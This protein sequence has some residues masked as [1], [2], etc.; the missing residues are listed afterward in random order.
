MHENGLESVLCGYLEGAVSRLSLAFAVLCVLFLSAPF[1]HAT[2]TVVSKTLTMVPSTT[3]YPTAGGAPAITLNY[4]TQYNGIV[5]NSTGPACTSDPVITITPNTT[6]AGGTF[7]PATCN[8]TFNIPNPSSG[9]NRSG[10]CS[11][12][13][14][15]PAAPAGNY[16]V[17]AAAQPVPNSTSLVITSA[18]STPVTLFRVPTVTIANTTNGAEAGPVN[19]RLTVTQ[20]N[21]LP[22]DT[23]ISLGYGGTAANGTDYTGP[24][25]VTILAGST[26][27]IVTL[28]TVDDALVE[29]SET[30]IV[31]LTGIT[32]GSAT[33]G[34]TTSATN[35][36][37]DND[38]ANVTIANTTDGAEPATA[39]TLT[40]TQSA[41]AATNT[42][43]NLTYGGTATNVTDYT[44]PATVTISAGSTTATVTLPVVD[45]STLEGTETVIVTLGS[46]ASGLATLGTPRVATNTIADN[47]TAS[48]AINSVS[49]AESGGSATFTATLTGVTQTAFTV[50]YATSDGT[51]LAGL[52]YTTRTGTLSF[53]ANTASPQ[54]RTFTVPVTNDVIVEATETATVTLSGL[55]NTFGGALTIT[56]PT[57]TL[58]I[59]DNDTAAVTIANTTN[60][61]EAGLV[62]G[63]MT[64]SQSRQSSTPTTVSYTVSGT[65]T[66][67][68]DYTPLSGSVVIPA[69]ALTASITIPILQDSLV[70]GAEA[71][72]VSL[73]AATSNVAITASGSATNTIADDDS[74]AVT[75][76]NTTDGNEA[77]LVAGVMTLSLSNPSATPTTVSY[78]VG[79]LASAATDYSAL[80]GSVVILA[81]ALTA[82][83]T[84]P[85]LQD[86]LVEGSETVIVNLSAATSNV[87][88]TASG[89]ATNTIADDDTSA[90][91]IANTTDGNEAGLVAGVMT[92]SL[93]NQSATPTTVSYSVSGSATSGTDYTVLSG[94]VIIPA[95]ALTATIT[96]PVLQD[97]LVEGSETVI[98]ALTA[99][100]SNVAITASG[101]ATNTLADDDASA[102]TIANTTDG[103]EAGLVAGITTV[104]LSNPSATPTTVSYI[105]S[106]SATSGTDYTALSGTVIVP[107]NTL[108]ATI[109]IPVLQDSIVEGPETVIV[110]LTAATSNVAITASGSA[111]NTLADDDASAATIANT[112]DG[113]EAGLVAGIMTVSLSN[114]SATPT[115]VS[116]SVNG[117]ATSGTD[118]TALSGSVIIPA[119][120]LT[121]TITI[122]V[123]QDSLVEGSETVIIALTS[124][125]SNVAITA[126]GSATNTMADD[127]ASAVTIANT[128]DGN[129]AGLVAGV[130]TVSLSNPSA[131][132]TTVSY[133]VSGSATSGTDYTALSGFVIVP[134][135]TLTATITI[136]VLQDS[137][138]EGPE[139]VIVSLTAAT[140]NVAITAS[141]STTNTIADDDVAVVTIVNAVNGAEPA[142]NGT[143]TVTQSAVSASDTIVVLSYGGTATNATDYTRPTSVTIPAGATTAIVTLAIV[144]DLIIEG[145]EFVDVTLASVSSGLATL[146]ATVLATNSVTDNDV[147]AL[148]IV[149][150]TNGAEPVTAG[151]LTVTQSA[152]SVSDSVIV[153]GYAGTATNGFDY[154]RPAS[155]TIPA[156]GTTATITLP[157]VDD[158][159]VEGTETVDVTLVSVTSG[160]ATLGTTITA[161]ST[162]ADNDVAVVTVANVTDAGEPATN[163]VLTV[164][165]LAVSVSDTVISYS[166]GGLAT[167]S[168]D[169]TPL[170]GT[171]TIPA[172]ATSASI[173]IGVLDDT[174]VEGPETIVITLTNI[175]SGLGV[176][177]GTPAATNTISDDDNAIDNIIRTAFKSQTHNFMARRE[178]LILS[179]EPTLHRLINRGKGDFAE[180][181]NGFNVVGLDGNIEGDFAFNGRAVANALRG[182]LQPDENRSS[183]LNAWVEGQFALYK[184]KSGSTDQ[185]GDFFVG[186]GGVDLRVNDRLLLG[187]M[188][189]IDW[190]EDRAAN[191]SD[192]VHGTGWMVGPYLSSEPFENVFFDLRAMWGQSSNS[193]IQDVLGSRFEG[194]FDTDRWLIDT[195]LAGN[196][197][198]DMLQLTPEMSL[199][200]M[201][202]TQ[203]N[204]SVGDGTRVVSVD[205][206]RVALGR[207]AAGLRVTYLGEIEGVIFEPFVG[208][209]VLWNFEDPGILNTDGSVASLDA[210]RGEISAGLNIIDGN[211]QFSL[212]TTYDGLG[213]NGLQAISA[214]L[215][216]AHQF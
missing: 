209:R 180:G 13:W 118:Y 72:V 85:V 102:A 113:N 190:A 28:S 163:G 173:A 208:G 185:K 129:E 141:G 181:T 22:T 107:A 63:V 26:T 192:R 212:E 17:R 91:T 69:N 148:T 10:T 46:I 201:S 16:V 202:E 97:S 29:G 104:S 171:I 186:Y 93:S 4:T 175:T 56:G 131:T 18:Q 176:L 194:N 156:G 179:H 117:T 47:D 122:P 37:A 161:T 110:S 137:I 35:T 162:L 178:D 34:T 77:G 126:S 138:V 52:D 145:A 98:I 99:A 51:A 30:A 120:T 73:V 155:V 196:Y 215:M 207:L 61:N 147:A 172:G 135:N 127:D 106:G 40:V 140:S 125:T 80:S 9:I 38:T 111:T 75:I 79:G 70:E 6:P 33:L 12:T 199:L 60:G 84:I 211:S 92:V 100:T 31:S 170:S 90:V 206:Q 144:D 50:A 81:N 191:S 165:Q 158:A 82:T 15:A 143:L 23:I 187:L 174:L 1:S 160:L 149:T 67:G 214:K 136:P 21:T 130:T 66:S 42:V 198:A 119:N 11:L 153:L 189:Q 3:L 74:S 146:G 96:I 188:A 36:I 43:I 109:T 197:R 112:T 184:D 62:S 157:I 139:T 58:T 132:P 115:T 133:I 41:T 101:S 121:A 123:L 203:K 164:S 216:F 94:S 210:L 183:L 105:V 108:T 7:S 64:V 44:R 83:I 32:S 53:A 68:S 57:G 78:S 54:T 134:A 128:T 103:N 159:L 114:P 200:Y 124:A 204:Y 166:V 167:S 25:S 151:V 182:T 142:T 87:A 88:I 45:D 39:G 14:T 24:T 213:S 150:T 2:C 27:A 116:Y 168:S 152:I 5:S 49:I 154:T 177:L 86:S 20:S 71:V 65:A 8:F 48:I 89:S 95:N 169:F 193:A 59:T 195:K 76:A 19:G 205:G 55:S